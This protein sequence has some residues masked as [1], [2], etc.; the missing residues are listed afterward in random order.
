M[1]HATGPVPTVTL[2]MLQKNRLFRGVSPASLELLLVELPAEVAQTGDWIIRE[3]EAADCMF[4]ILNGELE[5][6]SH[7]G[8]PNADVRVA[9][10]G[11]G[12]WVGEMALLDVQPRSASVRALAP[13]QLLRL[14]ASRL[15]QPLSGVD[16]SVY[17]SLITNIA[18]ELGR[19]L[20][21]ADRLIAGS[22]AAIARQ[23]VIESRRPPTKA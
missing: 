15:Q 22:S 7:G 16:Q 4:A 6:V 12:D 9:L 21:V 2:E 13:S 19:R 5:V 3:G 18:R 11:P 14:D 10:L 8:G 20:R 1:S 23:Y 17:A